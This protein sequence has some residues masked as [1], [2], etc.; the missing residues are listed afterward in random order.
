[1]QTRLVKK[2]SWRNSEA[3]KSMKFPVTAVLFSL[4]DIV[5]LDPSS[6]KLKI[7]AD[8][9]YKSMKEVSQSGECKYSDGKSV[10]NDRQHELDVGEELAAR[11]E[12][13]EEEVKQEQN[14][15]SGK[16][17]QIVFLNNLG[18]LSHA[19]AT[20]SIKKVDEAREKGSER[21]TRSLMKKYFNKESSR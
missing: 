1:M 10:D 12:L 6:K 19:E 15:K 11:Q 20:A 8:P 2:R 7:A 16:Q 9:V 4:E 3:D 13:G 5:N 17:D 14:Q 18:L 21:K